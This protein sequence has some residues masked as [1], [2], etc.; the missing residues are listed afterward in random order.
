MQNTVAATRL[1][2]TGAGAQ[3]ALRTQIETALE[4]LSRTLVRD[5]DAPVASDAARS[6]SNGHRLQTQSWVRFFG[7]VLAGWPHV[8]PEAFPDEGA[9]FGASVSVEDVDTGS[10]ETYTLMTGPLLDIDAGQVSLASP[11][12]HS[13]L[14]AS[15]GAVVVIQTP[16][17]L[18]R[19]RVLAVRTLREK[20]F[21][22][23]PHRSAA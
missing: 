22:D 6:R 4:T 15:P 11:I 7:Q 5:G 1:V 8:P 14:G 21:E 9:G 12:G 17:R 19:L 3:S 16:Q 10:R 2:E 23:A 20:L 13:L 18:R